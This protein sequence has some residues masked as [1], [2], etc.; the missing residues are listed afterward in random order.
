MSALNNYAGASINGGGSIIATARAG[1]ALDPSAGKTVFTVNT[2]DRKLDE[3]TL[4]NVNATRMPS[5][6]PM[7]MSIA[8]AISHGYLDLNGSTLVE[9]NVATTPTRVNP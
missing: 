1:F 7:W 3:V 8:A 2:S 9:L 5:G 6:P 4:V